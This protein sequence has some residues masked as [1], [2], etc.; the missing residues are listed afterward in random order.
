MEL[1]DADGPASWDW[2]EL[3]D[4]L[5]GIDDWVATLR[6]TKTAL[7]EPPLVDARDFLGR[8]AAQQAVLAVALLRIADRMHLD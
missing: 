7:G 6:M 8:L 5:Q 4:H 3:R 1:G 2:D